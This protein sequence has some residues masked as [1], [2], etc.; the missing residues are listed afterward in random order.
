MFNL[1]YLSQII[2]PVTTVFEIDL[3][4]GVYEIN[5]LF[6]IISH[7][8]PNIKINIIKVDT[9]QIWNCHIPYL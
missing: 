7:E 5:I 2:T 3:N 8:N 1:M 4:F 9:S 6:W